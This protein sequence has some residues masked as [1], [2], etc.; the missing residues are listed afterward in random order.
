MA[1]A[2]DSDTISQIF[3][4]SGGE[5]LAQDMTTLT[6]THPIPN[7][8]QTGNAGPLSA[9]PTNIAKEWVS[10]AYVTGI[11]AQVGLNITKS[12]WDD[13]IDMTLG[14]TKPVVTGFDCRNLWI[15]LQLKATENWE[16]DNGHLRFFLK[17]SN[18]EQLRARSLTRQFL[19]VYT[20]PKDRS[21]SRW[22][23]QKSEHVEF[24]SRAFYLD[25]LNAPQLTVKANGRR[26]CGKTVRIPVANRLTACSLHKLYLD[27]AEWTK[28]ILNP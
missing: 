22:I 18:Y 14:S 13:G 5:G 25:L 11:A 27:A 9:I 17:Q 19:V 1:F 21:R 26:R 24:S 3:E 6:L 16:I 28:R 4:I 7:P 15:S 10:V 23:L 8:P 12:V 2:R 20:L